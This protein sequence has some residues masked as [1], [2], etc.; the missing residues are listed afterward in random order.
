MRTSCPVTAKLARPQYASSE[1]ATFSGLVPS[2]YRPTEVVAV[3]EQML[4]Y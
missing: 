1:V 3:E 2:D 4:D